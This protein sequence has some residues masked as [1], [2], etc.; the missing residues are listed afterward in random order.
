MAAALVLYFGANLGPIIWGL[1]NVLYAMTAGALGYLSRTT[2]PEV[3]LGFKPRVFIV[4][5]LAAGFVGSVALMLCMLLEWND[6]ATLVLVG[7]FGWMGAP[8]SMVIIEKFI[9]NKL[10]ITK[11]ADLPKTGN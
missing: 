9:Y 11:D 10:G 3:D 2:S 6:Y 1:L 7:F 5:T 4:Q 8:A